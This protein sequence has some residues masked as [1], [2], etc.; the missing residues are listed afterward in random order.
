MFSRR[1]VRKLAHESGFTTAVVMGM[2]LVGMLLVAAA[3]AM[4]NG[5][6]TSTRHDQYYKEAYNAA[7]AGVNWYLYH[8]T[9][10]ANYWSHCAQTTGTDKNSPPVYDNTETS[11]SWTSIPSSEAQFMIDL[12]PAP[13]QSKCVVNTST[14]IVDPTT[15]SF[16]VRSTG[17]Y[18]GVH[19]SIVATFRRVGFL[20]FLYFTD[21]E[22]LDPATY[23][24]AAAQ[25]A[26]TTNCA[27]YY[28]VSARDPSKCTEI[29]FVGADRVDGPLH[30]NDELYICGNPTFGHQSS[31]HIESS[32]PL[33][34]SHPGYRTD[35]G[36]SGSGLGGVIGHWTAPAHVLTLP[37]S[38]AELKADADPTTGIL[39]GTNHIVLRKSDMLVNGTATAYPSNGVIYDQNDTCT[40]SYDT[41]QDYTPAV[42]NGTGCGDVYISSLTGSS[43]PATDLTI[44]ADNDIVIDGNIDHAAGNEIGL[45]AN[46]FVRVYHPVD[47]SNCGNSNGN[48]SDSD[49]DAG[50]GSLSNLSIKAA[51]LAINHSF[52]VDNW[53]CGSPL[54]SLSVTGAI[55]QKFRGPVGTN[56]NGN[57]ASG[58]AKN[59]SYDYTLRYHQPPFFLDPVQAGWGIL[60]ETEQSPAAH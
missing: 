38:N 41:T 39:T 24:S 25:Q 10:D 47:R 27:H 12:L 14:S 11:F 8:L 48:A 56:N 28:Y 2:M 60:S 50:H 7:E 32:S 26:A 46:N 17:N 18:R 57:V 13:G 21:I 37:P 16:K 5:D 4:A 1:R 33:P 20:D 15:G 51:I 44:A 54:G 9:Q 55:A 23:G 30:T 42:T 58:Y 31:D 59:Y 49:A 53:N 22:T 35:S 19:R 52:I 40:P 43:A 6:T 3:L 29:E 34:T 36:C 45:I